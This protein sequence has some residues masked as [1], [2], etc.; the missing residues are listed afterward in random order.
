MR[1]PPFASVS[2][3]DRAINLAIKSARRVLPHRPVTNRLSSCAAGTGQAQQQPV[4][5]RS[6]VPYTVTPIRCESP[7]LMVDHRN[8]LLHTA[9]NDPAADHKAVSAVLGQVAEVF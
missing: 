2:E 7:G 1:V 5:R 4:T 8:A 9:L 6:T 3:A